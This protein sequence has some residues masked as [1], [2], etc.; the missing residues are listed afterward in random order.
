MADKFTEIIARIKKKKEL[1]GLDSSLV[2][3]TLSDYL[4]K[5]KLSLESVN[6]SGIKIIVKEIRAELRK[7]SGMFQQ[8]GWK[9]RHEFLEKNDVSSLLQSHLSTKERIN[10]YPELKKVIEGLGVKS[11]LE[12]GCGINPIALA[13]PGIKYHAS[14]INK[15][16]LALVNEF[17]E[18]NKIDGETF[19]CDL[20]KID[21]C[22]LPKADLCIVLKVFDIIE[23]KSHKLAEKILLKAG[24]K[25]LIISFS[26]KTLS[27][28]S[29]GRAKVGWIEHLLKRIGYKFEIMRSQNEIFYIAKNSSS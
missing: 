8:K 13:V 24:S 28:K 6:E 11:I 17:F 21:E 12:L 20:K 14:D 2:S 7:Y 29:M 1:S 5:R 25:N 23:K 19:I 27:G 3:N 26:T 22:R 18:K 10:F 16:E 15:D 9:D 4:K